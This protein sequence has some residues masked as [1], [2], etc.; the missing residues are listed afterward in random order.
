MFEG[1]FNEIIVKTV[2]F[3]GE[4]LNVTGRLI[5]YFKVFKKMLGGGSSISNFV[6]IAKK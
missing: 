5:H 4:N 1:V 6:I 3:K 2:I